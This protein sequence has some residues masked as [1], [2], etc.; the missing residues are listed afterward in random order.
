MKQN[1]LINIAGPL[2]AQGPWLKPVR[3]RRRYAVIQ[4]N[5]STW[6]KSLE[7]M[8]TF[9]YFLFVNTAV[10]VIL[11]N[12]ESIKINGFGLASMH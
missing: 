1:L 10:I 11:Q 6:F 12:K 4:V 7:Y 2:T 3:A 5:L 9:F 8:H